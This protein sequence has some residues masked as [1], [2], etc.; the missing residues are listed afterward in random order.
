MSLSGKKKVGCSDLALRDTQEL[1][2]WGLTLAGCSKGWVEKGGVQG[3][4]KG[5][6]QEKR[7]KSELFPRK[8][9]GLMYPL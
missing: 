8:I 5:V 3:A 7:G 9:R 2:S 4:R 6:A 1:G